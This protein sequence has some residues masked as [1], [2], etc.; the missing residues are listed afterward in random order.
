MGGITQEMRWNLHKYGKTKY[1]GCF[2][3]AGALLLR[4]GCWHT[5]VPSFVTIMMLLPAQCQIIGPPVW[6]FAPENNLRYPDAAH[7]RDCYRR[8]ISC[9]S[10]IPDFETFRSFL[11]EKLLRQRS[12]C[13]PKS[14]WTEI[15]WGKQYN[16]YIFKWEKREIPHNSSTCVI[17]FRLVYP[18]HPQTVSRR[19]LYRHA[20]PAAAAAPVKKSICAN[21]CLG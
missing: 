5:D 7:Q 9:V 12:A 17:D 19:A 13:S 10:E 20:L 11:H 2:S 14:D 16:I 8:W 6:T 1:G 18:P 15:L 4:P 3:P 21:H